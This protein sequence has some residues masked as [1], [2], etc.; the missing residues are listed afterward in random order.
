MLCLS[1]KTGQTV[2]INETITITVTEIHGGRVV[3]GFEAP[4]HIGIRRG[5]LPPGP[6]KLEGPR[7]AE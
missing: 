5:E 1:R 6:V 7:E 4:V 2:V 3:L